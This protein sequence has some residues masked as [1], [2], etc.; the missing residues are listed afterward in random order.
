[1]YIHLPS[2]FP[3]VSPASPHRNGP[4]GG[5]SDFTC[6]SLV[7]KAPCCEPSW[8]MKT[9]R[10][11]YRDVGISWWFHDDFIVFSRFHDGLSW[12]FNGDCMLVFSFMVIGCWFNGDLLDLIVISSC[13]NNGLIM[14][15]VIT[16]MRSGEWREPF[17]ALGSPISL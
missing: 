12:W 5:A 3:W 1:M 7:K 16:Y 17:W 13:V 8:A 2:D 11:T 14:I 10:E 9:Y 6:F 4:S 15:N